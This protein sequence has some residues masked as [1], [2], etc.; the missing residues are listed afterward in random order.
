VAGELATNLTKPTLGS[1]GLGAIST[2]TGSTLGD[3]LVGAGIGYLIAP[4]Q[5]ERLSYSAWGAVAGGL[6]GVLGLGVLIAVR[7]WP[8]S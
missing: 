4:E 5:D 7:F 6:G 1:V 3:G 8:R 2:G